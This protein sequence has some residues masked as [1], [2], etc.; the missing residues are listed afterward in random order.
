MQSAAPLSLV[1]QA[2]RPGAGDL[3]RRV[4][5][6]VAWQYGLTVFRVLI[7]VGSTAV[8]A[9][10]L[11][12]TDYGLVAMAALVTELAAL[13]TNTGFGAILVQRARISRLDLDTA[14]WT[15]V[16][17]GA[18]LALMV[19]AV[20][21]PAALVFGEPALFGI[22]CVSALNFVIQGAAVAPTA[23]L[24]RLMLFRIDAY[25]QAVQLIVRTVAAV[26]MAWAG[27]GYWSLVL[28]GL[29]SGLTA[30]VIELVIVRFI[31]RM[32][33]NASFVRRNIS[34]SGSY[35]GTSMLSFVLANVDQFTIARRFGAEQLGFYQAALTLP[36]ELRNRVAAPLQRVLFP[37]FAL[38]QSDLGRFREVALTA[39]KLL[40]SVVLPIGTVLAIS[41]DDIVAL[42][43]GEKWSAVVPLL[44]VLAL[45]GALRAIFGLVGNIY[46]AMGRPE[47]AL[48][49]NLMATPIV[50]IGV[51]IGSSFGPIGVAW[52]MLLANGLGFYSAAVAMRL[53]GGT[54][55]AFLKALVPAVTASLIAAFALITVRHVLGPN[56][57]PAASLVVGLPIFAIVMV[58]V[59]WRMD[60]ALFVMLRARLQRT[61][62]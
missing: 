2:M 58:S 8:L 32:R 37:A 60:R 38:L 50:I 4:T 52:A 7:T 13:L 17:I 45:G 59:L 41:A 44:Q 11:T 54:F 31:P 56:L 51:L 49:I 40:A 55:G 25:I 18:V 27:F 43:Y 9:R 26:I 21:Y 10:L 28:A 5:H 14:F 29:I 35:V 53:I 23:V 47:L 22:L 62:P 42:L 15:S 30:C 3:G 24:N 1:R 12:P 19:V 34:A 39:Q 16:G 46:F 33:F 36:G 6:G 61:P 48:R 20:A 57:G